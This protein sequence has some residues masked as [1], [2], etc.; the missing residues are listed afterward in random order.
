MIVFHNMTMQTTAVPFINVPLPLILFNTP[1]TILF[2]KQIEKPQHTELRF[3]CI[4]RISI[5]L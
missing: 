3:I 2:L 1:L 4:M 5:N